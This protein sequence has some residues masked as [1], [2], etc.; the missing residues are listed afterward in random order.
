M[1]SIS[2]GSE[3]LILYSLVKNLTVSNPDLKALFSNAF[4]G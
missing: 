1:I 4:L 3:E 2:T